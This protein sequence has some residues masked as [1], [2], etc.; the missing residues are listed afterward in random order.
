MEF[1]ELT[2][3]DAAGVLPNET[4]VTAVK[5]VP[6]I[7]TVVPPPVDPDAGLMPVT[8]GVGTW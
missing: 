6:L 8:A 4:P 3:N 5:F 2:V 7:V 1:D